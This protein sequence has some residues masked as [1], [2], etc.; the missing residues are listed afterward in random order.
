MTGVWLSIEG[1]TQAKCDVQ[2]QPVNWLSPGSYCIILEHCYPGKNERVHSKF[3]TADSQVNFWEQPFVT[4]GGLVAGSLRGVQKPRWVSHAQQVPE[5]MGDSWPARGAYNQLLRSSK[6]NEQLKAEHRRAHGNTHSV[7]V[8]FQGVQ[9]SLPTARAR[10]GFWVEVE[11]EWGLEGWVKF[12]RWL[13]HSRQIQEL[14]K[15]RFL[16]SDWAC[17]AEKEG[18]MTGPSPA[19]GLN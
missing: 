11:P 19:C 7:A 17:L 4:K 18:N 9:R 15:G 5:V 1:Y 14:V 2:C 12:Q 8:G 13:V 10:E 3:Q 16:G 6:S